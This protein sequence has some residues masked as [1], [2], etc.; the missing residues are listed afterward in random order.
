MAVMP[1]PHAVAR[2]NR[3]LLNPLV[4]RM[5]SRVPPFA[6]VHHHGRRSGR[7]FATP[8]MA[9]REPASATAPHEVRVVIALTYGPDVD[10][11]RNVEAVGLF[12]LTRGG[13]GYVVDDLR[14][15]RGDAGLRLVPGVIRV[16][17]RVLRV[18]EFLDGRV[19]PPR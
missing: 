17:L 2:T 5:S 9:F 3:R 19:G 14:R 1:I 6:T 12:G 11:L 7:P 10:W 16:A 18:D 8:V 15:L 4:L 13:R